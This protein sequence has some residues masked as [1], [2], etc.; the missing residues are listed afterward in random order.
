MTVD[1]KKTFSPEEI[2]ARLK[3]DLPHWRYEDGWIR[4][5]FPPTAGRAR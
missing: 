3:A 1:R 5:T 2:E 4:R